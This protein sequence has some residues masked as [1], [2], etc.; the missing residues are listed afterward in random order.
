MCF[1]NGMLAFYLKPCNYMYILKKRHEK[2]QIDFSSTQNVMDC[3]PKLP[4]CKPKVKA[5]DTLD[6]SQEPCP[7]DSS[8][9][10]PLA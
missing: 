10:M 5:H 9:N 2:F 4:S 6:D 3:S 7:N 8:V 1:A